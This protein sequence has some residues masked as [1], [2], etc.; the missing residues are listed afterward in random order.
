M[1]TTPE[2]DTP[3]AEPEMTR[4]EKLDQIGAWEDEAARESVYS[5]YMRP[6]DV[7]LARYRA[8]IQLG[9]FALPTNPDFRLHSIAIPTDDGWV[10]ASDYMTNEQVDTYYAA[11]KAVSG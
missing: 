1:P 7:E 10:F 3:A 6:N 2:T 11:L 5:H 4:A 8:A 9:T